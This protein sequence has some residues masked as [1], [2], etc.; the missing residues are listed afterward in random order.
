[1]DWKR[2]FSS[3]NASVQQIHADTKDAVRNHLK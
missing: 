3:E 1:M 2:N